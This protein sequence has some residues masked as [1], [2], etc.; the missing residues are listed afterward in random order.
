MHHNIFAKTK[1]NIFKVL[2]ID[3]AINLYERY[4]SKMTKSIDQ[5]NE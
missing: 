5:I 1:Q 3:E 2:E 4:L